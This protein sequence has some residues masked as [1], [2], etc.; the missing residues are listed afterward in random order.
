MEGVGSRPS[1]VSDS[2]EDDDLFIPSTR[3]TDEI[4]LRNRRPKSMHY[5]FILH[6]PLLNI[7]LP[8]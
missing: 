4:L 8:A 1:S 5:T 7:R 2:R 6:N 3:I